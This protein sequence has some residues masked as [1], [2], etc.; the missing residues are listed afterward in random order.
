LESEGRGGEC[1]PGAVTVGA[2]KKKDDVV[3]GLKIVR[4]WGS[5][6]SGSECNSGAVTVGA[7]KLRNDVV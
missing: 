5:E 3:Q 1:N 4:L 2:K 7:K 6:G